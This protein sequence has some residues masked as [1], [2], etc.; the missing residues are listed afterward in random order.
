MNFFI[1]Y[2][3]NQNPNL[4]IKEIYEG[5]LMK[6]ST[7]SLLLY[8]WSFFENLLEKIMGITGNLYDIKK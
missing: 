4:M 3:I 6:T 8:L 2:F 7:K 5:K 1:I